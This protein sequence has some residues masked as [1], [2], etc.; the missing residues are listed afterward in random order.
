MAVADGTAPTGACTGAGAG[1]GPASEV[2]SVVLDLV[3]LSPE[4]IG[5][6]PDSVLGALLRQVYGSCAEG[7]PF[8]TGH[9]ESV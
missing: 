6:L 2:E 1:E 5:A 3:A 4:D 9:S 7:N 8:V